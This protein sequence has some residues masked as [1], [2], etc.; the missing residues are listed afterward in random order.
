M[1]RLTAERMGSLLA[2]RAA[3]PLATSSARMASHGHEVATTVDM[4]KP[5]YYDRK[6]TPLPDRAYKDVLDT[7][8]KGLKQ[9][10]KGP[11][12]QLSKEEKIALYR[13]MFCQTY[14]EMKQP[15][16]E[17]KTV[18]GGIFILLGLTGLIVWW[19]SIYVYPERPR[20]FDEE[21]KAK[22]LKRMLDMRINPVEGFSA[23]WD[24]EKGQWK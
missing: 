18:M 10:E 16:D 20:T 24:Y 17:W 5:L 21:W 19:Q 2:R 3:M 15:S 14:A 8:D 12:G 22:Q 11:W 23:K 7:A 13:I 4:S 9:K 6:D 1:L